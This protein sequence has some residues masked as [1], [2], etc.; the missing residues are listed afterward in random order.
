MTII[1]YSRLEWTLINLFTHHTGSITTEPIEQQWYWPHVQ[2]LVR[3]AKG[4]L[5]AEEWAVE[6]MRRLCI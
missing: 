5:N 6:L 2:D 4:G 1:T 3:Y